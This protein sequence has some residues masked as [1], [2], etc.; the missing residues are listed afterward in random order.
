MS[1]RNKLNEVKKV[2]NI[3]NDLELSKFLKTNKHNIDSWVKRNK[4]PNSWLNYIELLL[5]KREN[6]VNMTHSI[7]I[8][9][10]VLLL[11]TYG[12]PKI[13]QELKNKLLTIKNIDDKTI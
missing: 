13:L 4:I 10:I 12:T 3:S 8:D 11:K 6:A 7:E 5:Q 2:Y 1:A 9:E